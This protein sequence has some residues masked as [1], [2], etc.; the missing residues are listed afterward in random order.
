MGNHNHSQY[1]FKLLL[2]SNS[3]ILFA[4]LLKKIFIILLIILKYFK[5]IIYI[6][7]KF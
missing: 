7:F 4:K 5:K 2:N 1:L 3:F 6:F